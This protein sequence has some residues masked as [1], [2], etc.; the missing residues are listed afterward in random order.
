M[1]YVSKGI[2]KIAEEIKLVVHVVT[3]YV[4]NTN[5]VHI[6]ATNHQFSSRND[7]KGHIFLMNVIKICIHYQFFVK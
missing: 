3:I 4:K 1:Y 5:F 6:F 7:W 2:L